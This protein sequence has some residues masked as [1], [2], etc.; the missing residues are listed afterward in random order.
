MCNN[1]FA[2]ARARDFFGNQIVK[3]GD[4]RT[5]GIEGKYSF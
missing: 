3:R 5:F 4:P 2:T 1:R